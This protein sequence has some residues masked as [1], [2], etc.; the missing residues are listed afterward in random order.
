M[1]GSLS[2]M[3]FLKKFFRDPTNLRFILRIILYVTISLLLAWIIRGRP[4]ITRKDVVE[5]SVILLILLAWMAPFFLL[6]RLGET[7]K[8]RYAE[9]MVRREN[10]FWNDPYNRM[11]FNNLLTF[12]LLTSIVVYFL[13]GDSF[14]YR[15][16]FFIQPYDRTRI[17]AGSLFFTEATCECWR[18]SSNS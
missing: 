1:N 2:E 3:Q 13:S 10:L 8:T 16:F 9:E 5:L 12:I 4:E 15:L 7:V 6:L 14:W 18:V 11:L 17:L